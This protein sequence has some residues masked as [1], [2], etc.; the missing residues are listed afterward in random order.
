MKV[1]LII[2]GS[3]AGVSS[4][5]YREL[6]PH[7]LPMSIAYLAGAVEQAGYEV[8]LIDQIARRLSNQDLVN[9]L[10]HEVPDV[11]GF[12]LLTTTVPNVLDTVRL[13]RGHVP[14][15]KIMMGNH[16][17][18]LFADDLLRNEAADLIVRGEG[19]ITIVEALRALDAGKSLRK[20]AGLSYRTRNGRVYHNPSRVPIE[21]LDTVSY[22]AWHLVD[23][24]DRKYMELPLIGV[25]STPVPIMAS[26]G[27]P[28]SCVFCSQ[29]TQFKKVRLRK[30]KNVVDE[31]EHHIDTYGFEW[32]GFNDAYF[33]WTKRQGF[34]FADE[35][36]RRGLHRKVRWITE[37][38]VDMVDEELMLRL[39]ESGLSVIFFGFESGNQRV[40]DLAGK[41]T[42]LAQA[43]RAA[44]AA[45]N[46]GVTV[47]GFFMLG[48]PGDTRE[49]CWETVNFAIK[50]DCDFAKFAVTIPYPGSKLYEMQKDRFDSTQF[51]KFTSWYN[52][53]SGD[54]ELLSAP[55]GMTVKELLA[56]QRTGMLKFYAR[57][58]QVYRHLT[59]GTLSLRH[60]AYG[61]YVL[62]EGALK[63]AA[64]EARGLFFGE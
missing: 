47:M 21:N 58:T 12:S 8:I 4:A 1:A 19:E 26:R 9:L 63:N 6:F 49:T 3:K 17:A 64:N 57:P 7:L 45:R 61:A 15:A 32:F 44:R 13:I 34:E 56:I 2:P 33:P 27:C 25:Y 51:E 10:R 54:E 39:R 46:A 31:V 20:V 14:E 35:L 38:R 30:V 43:E 28:F 24:F 55:E 29:D 60:M 52:W 37:S 48:L 11:I 59:G 62:V 36:I 53:A 18:S 22:P 40:L 41:R 50:L 42:T 5:R 23:L 16:H